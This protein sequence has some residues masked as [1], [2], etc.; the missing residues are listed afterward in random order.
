[1]AKLIDLAAERAVLGGIFNHGSAAYYEVADIIQPSSFTDK[2]NQAIYKCFQHLVDVKQIEKFDISSVMS[3]ANELG[4][5][6]IFSNKDENNH[7]IAI[8]NTNVILNN[9][10]T[11]AAK[12]RKLEIAKLLCEQLKQSHRNLRSIKGNEPID[13]IIGLVENP[14]FDF[15]QLLLGQSADNDTKK[16]GC[17][18]SDYIKNIEENPGM[19]IGIPTG[20]QYFDEIIGGGIRRKT[21]GLIGARSGIG[22]SYIANNIA[23][24]N[25]E[26]NTPVLYLDTEMEKEDHYPRALANLCYKS[27]FKITINDIER[28]VFVKNK[29]AK[30]KINIAVKQLEELPYYYINIS[31]KPFEETLSIIR[32]WIHKHVGFDVNGRTN[33]CL[34]IYDYVKLT[35]GKDLHNNLAEYQQLGFQ[36]IS[37]HNFTI[38]HDVPVLSFIQL[39]REGIDRETQGV[40]AGSDRVLWTVTHFSIFKDKAP[41]EIEED[42]PEKGDKK[43]VNLKHRHGE[44]MVPGNYINMIMH[45][46]YGI[47]QECST[48]H[49]QFAS[50]KIGVDEEYATEIEPEVQ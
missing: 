29:T 17:N 1:M 12:L 49:A 15:T 2:G 25:A 32:R 48:K 34:I 27:G 5:T 4:F 33:D 47:V 9:V 42:G 21:V 26:H 24:Y 28:G 23:L 41:E 30:T 6:W 18:V 31:G 20:F 13:A 45:G 22:K 36:L 46:K 39:N 19:I 37:M 8:T 10:I 35:D 50:D 44:G 11:W 40:I 14:I 3:A 7:F 38:K 43:L 16:F